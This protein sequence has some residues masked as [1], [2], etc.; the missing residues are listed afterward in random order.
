MLSLF[1]IVSEH[2]LHKLE[3][4][5]IK[6][7]HS[8]E[9]KWAWVMD[10]TAEARAGGYT[11]S[12]TYEGLQSPNRR[13]NLVDNPGHKDFAHNSGCGIFHAD[14]L[15]LVTS[16]LKSE[17]EVAEISATERSQAE[18]HL[19]TAFCNGI[20]QVVV[21]INKMDITNYSESSYTEVSTHIRKKL[22]KAGFKDAQYRLIPVSARSGEG[23][24]STS[25]L[26]PWYT[27]ECLMEVLYY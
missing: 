21:V 27:G 11:I 8:G 9:L 18:E 23:F 7:G 14:V 19:L 3:K 16:A 25:S 12:S 1:G 10:R 5:A 20:R 24:L 22:R 15:V 13:F 17:I 2:T 26:M 6:L 4:E